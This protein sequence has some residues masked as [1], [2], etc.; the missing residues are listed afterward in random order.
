LGVVGKAI[1]VADLHTPGFG[2]DRMEG[3]T[4]IQLSCPN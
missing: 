1:G 2:F 4:S 3:I